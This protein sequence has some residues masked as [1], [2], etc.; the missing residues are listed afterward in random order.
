MD[1]DDWLNENLPRPPRK[2]RERCPLLSRSPSGGPQGQLLLGFRFWEK[3]HVPG[4]QL[5]C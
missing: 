1:A 2:L 5:C 3:L 4:A